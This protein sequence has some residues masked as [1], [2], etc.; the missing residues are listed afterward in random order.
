MK[1]INNYYLNGSTIVEYVRDRKNIDTNYTAASV[2]EY[3]SRGGALSLSEQQ[4]NDVLNEREK[5]PKTFKAIR[6]LVRMG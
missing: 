1:D 6:N 4:I 3:L 5:D 2:F